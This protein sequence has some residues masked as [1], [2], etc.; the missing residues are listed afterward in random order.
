[1]S[2]ETK[3]Y[4]DVCKKETPINQMMELHYQCHFHAAH[5]YLEFR[6]KYKERNT[7]T[8]ICGECCIKAGIIVKRIVTDTT[9][10]PTP[11]ENF[12]EWLIEEVSERVYDGLNQ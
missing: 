11:A 2:T 10:E 1:M 7:I 6:S 9:L 8:H 5:Q 12:I 3:Y 4:C